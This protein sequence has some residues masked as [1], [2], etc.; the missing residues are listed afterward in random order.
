[1]G[2]EMRAF[3]R[4]RSKELEREAASLRA[5]I[6]GHKRVIQEA[7]TP[8]SDPADDAL[9]AQEQAKSLALV[10]QMEQQLAQVLAARRKLADGTY[11]LCEVCH[12]P[13]VRERLEAMPYARLCTDCQSARERKNHLHPAGM[14]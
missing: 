11:G 8:V 3:I 9:E 7:G 14:A 12:K 10:I 1:M 4:A 13:I 5:A 2:R 6:A